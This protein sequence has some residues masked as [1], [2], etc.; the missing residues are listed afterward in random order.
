MAEQKLWQWENGLWRWDDGLWRW[1]EN[2][3]K[4]ETQCK[5]IPPEDL[6]FYPCPRK[7]KPSGSTTSW[8]EELN[9][10]EKD[11][12]EWE[13]MLRKREKNLK[14]KGYLREKEDAINT[15]ESAKS[16]CP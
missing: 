4:R 2:I 9:E 11:L 12:R 3:E 13:V 7:K 10:W 5:V 1:E 16:D 6:C 8:E 15:M 14:G